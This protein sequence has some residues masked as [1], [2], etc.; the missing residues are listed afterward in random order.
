MKSCF[1]A[2]WTANNFY[3]QFV[4]VLF[5]S[6]LYSAPDIKISCLKA[7]QKTWIKE[8][9]FMEIGFRRFKYHIQKNQEQYSLLIRNTKK[10]S[11]SHFLSKHQHIL[12][13]SGTLVTNLLLLSNV[14]CSIMFKR[15]RNNWYYLVIINTNKKFS[16]YQNEL[17]SDQMLSRRIIISFLVAQCTVPDMKII[18]ICL[19]AKKHGSKSLH[20]SKF[21][22]KARSGQQISSWTSKYQN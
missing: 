15:I 5:P 4:S 7:K 17:L 2:N 22:W 6:L 14:F 18:I 20:S 1:F 10:A 16:K 12:H 9:S 19:K 21:N 8:S 3:I 13:C 11:I